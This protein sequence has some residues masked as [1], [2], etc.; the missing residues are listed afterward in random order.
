[1]TIGQLAGRTGVGVDTVRFYERRGLLPEPPRTTAGYR[2]Y[3]EAS[4][5]RLRFILRAK[6]LGFSLGETSDL[7]SL[8]LDTGACAADVRARAE[9]K[10]GE[11]V[12]K[13]EDLERMRRSLLGLID[14]CGGQGDIRGCPILQDLSREVGA[15]G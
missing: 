8:R 13:I 12:E 4:V 11:I 15:G 10:V 6:A 7:L 9:E 14:E 5:G 2:V 1:M 3:D